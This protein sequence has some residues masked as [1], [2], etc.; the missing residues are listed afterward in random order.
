[1][2]ATTL[3]STAT[4]TRTWTVAA[5]VASGVLFALFPVLRPW[6]DET[7]PSADL[8]TAY[9]SDRWILAHLCGI[10]ALTLLGPA[11]LGLRSL[12]AGTPG[13]RVAGWALGTAWAGAACA[14]LY[15]GAEMF[16][17]HVLATDTPGGQP[18]LDLVAALREQPVAMTLF[19]AGLL[20]LAASG[21]LAAVAVVRSQRYPAT[22]GVL[23]AVALVLL[24][25]QFWGGP[26]VRIGHGLLY[27]AGCGVVAYVLGRRRSG[28]DHGRSL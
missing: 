6:A 3:V 19:A 12:L 28:S 26:A 20:L 15:F 14:G 25:P 13:E 23:L 22:S 27:A 1:M 8:V 18:L 11:L 4:R 2:S 9:A 16:G 10:A 7:T 17:I 5:F 21:V 24:T